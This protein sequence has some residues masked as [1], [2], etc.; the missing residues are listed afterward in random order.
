M[1]VLLVNGSP[2][3]KGCT[4][5]ALSVI[6][7][8]LEECGV[9]SEIFQLGAAPVG[10]CMA[11]P[12][13]KGKTEGKCVIDSDPV[14]ALIE[15]A[16]EADAFVFGSPVYY[17]HPTGR[18]LSALDRA[19]CSG[20]KHF[21]GKPGAAIVS[22]RR[23]GTTAALD[24]INKYFSIS[25]MPIVTSNY[26]NMVHGNKPEEVLQDAEGIQI[27]RVLARNMAW[28]LQCMEAAEKA[29]VQRPA[30]E[31]KIKMNFIR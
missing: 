15:K 17:A 3:A 13:C 19:F 8:T 16:A 31:A 23:A 20:G 6:A 26:W 14:N 18:L 4:Y 1:K 28:M 29:G 21:A 2:R 25:Q 10:D 7:D 11:C 30:P 12:T 5:T 9:E 24:V 22:G 27:M